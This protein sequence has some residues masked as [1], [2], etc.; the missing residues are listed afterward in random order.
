MLFCGDYKSKNY[1]CKMD[2]VFV[3]DKR[4]KVGGVRIKISW[5]F[6]SFARA[7]S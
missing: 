5:S 7:Y 6:K 2:V 1:T 3:N 4:S